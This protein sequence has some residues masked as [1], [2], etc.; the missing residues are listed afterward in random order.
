MA[1]FLI[2][3]Q[4]KRATFSTTGSSANTT[5]RKEALFSVS[6]G[7]SLNATE[8]AAARAR[9]IEDGETFKTLEWVGY[10]RHDLKRQRRTNP[11]LTADAARTQ[12]QGM[13]SS[14]HF[15]RVS[16]GREQALW[17]PA[18]HSGQPLVVQAWRAITSD[19]EPSLFYTAS[20]LTEQCAHSMDLGH[21]HNPINYNPLSQILK[22]EAQRSNDSPSVKVPEPDLETR[23]SAEVSS[24]RLLLS[25][26]HAL[27]ISLLTRISHAWSG[28]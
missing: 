16:A 9:G 5:R 1:I 25:N 6:A 2:C 20:W 23:S 28:G 15:I 12:P 13:L 27:H 22:T 10:R 24:P 4:R 11:K 18:I 19:R 7:L 14:G 17:P 8:I 3:I 26:G 21:H